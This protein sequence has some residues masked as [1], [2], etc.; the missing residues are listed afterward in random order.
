MA[1]GELGLG[2]LFL[3]GSGP[4]FDAG[5]NA[6][7]RAFELGVNYV[8]T[9]PA[10]GDSEAAVGMILGSSDAQ[11]LVS[12]KLGGRPDPF[13]PRDKR[14]LRRSVEE[15]L[16][17][18]RRDH[19]DVLMIHE[20]DRPGQYGWWSDGDAVEGPVLELLDE[21]KRE[22][23]VR[24]TG[25]GGTTAYELARLCATGK[26]DVVLTAFNYSVLWREAEIEVLPAAREHDMGIVIGS[27]LQQGA[28]ASRHDEEIARGARWLSAPRRQQYRELYALLDEAGLGVAEAAL[29]FVLSNPNVCCALTGMRS[30]DEVERNA[31]AVAAG[32][33]PQDVL[34][35]LQEIAARVPFRPF[36][37]P[38][39]L[40]FGAAYT[41]PGPMV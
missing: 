14:C 22:G 20:P 25:L 26:F 18:L 27:P 24:F 23:T 38:P 7:A 4:A 34:A 3:S 39:C 37:E 10:Y 36:D 8:D 1:V 32:P 33:L 31:R 2:G 19:I 5:R 15:S 28:L 35:E 29:R 6:A 11:V 9:A 21:L 12:T 17:L 41:G 30:A 16:R 40:P 13:M